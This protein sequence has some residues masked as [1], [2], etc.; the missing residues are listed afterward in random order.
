MKTP[1]LDVCLDSWAVQSEVSS[2]FR[3]MFNSANDR[4]E[5]DNVTV[6]E[7][8]SDSFCIFWEAS[9]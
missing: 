8:V 9:P 2:M 7:D 1:A 6:C 4:S 5:A 3:S